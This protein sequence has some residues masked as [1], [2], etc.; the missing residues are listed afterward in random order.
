MNT[1]KTLACALLLLGTGL[2]MTSTTSA[3]FPCEGEAWTI[4]F[5]EH[6]VRGG[7]TYDEAWEYL[8]DSGCDA[9]MVRKVICQ[10]YP[11]ACAVPLDLEAAGIKIKTGDGGVVVYDACERAS[12]DNQY[13]CRAKHLPTVPALP[14][15]PLHPAIGFSDVYEPCPPGTYEVM[16]A[17]AQPS[18]AY[19]Q[20][21]DGF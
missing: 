4:H 1:K 11:G 12:A 7:L 10:Y 2:A 13:G 6:A 5:V 18:G 15:L 9:D 16:W 8:M 19:V 17:Q 21:C 20:I 3:H 14:T